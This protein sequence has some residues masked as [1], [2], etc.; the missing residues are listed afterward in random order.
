M[1]SLPGPLLI[2]CA[3]LVAG[4][5]SGDAQQPVAR[6]IHATLQRVAGPYA[7]DSVHALQKDSVVLVLRDTTLTATALEAG[8]WMFGPP[9]TKAEE[10]G[11]PPEKV[12]GRRLARL[13]WAELGRPATLQLV[14]VRVRGPM[15]GDPLGTLRK[16][17]VDLFYPRF[18]LTGPWVGDRP[19]IERTLLVPNAAV[20]IGGSA[21]LARPL[22]TQSF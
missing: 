16:V 9:T 2:L 4:A 6:A 20:S 12:L 3:A 11:C 10:D 19:E 8:T 18:Q 14:T 1:R 21:L 13:V 7:L 15:T 17:S 22:I 5:T